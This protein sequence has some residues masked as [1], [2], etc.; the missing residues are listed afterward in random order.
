M[1]YVDSRANVFN[2]EDVYLNSQLACAAMSTTV[3]SLLA[4]CLVAFVSLTTSATSTPCMSGHCH[5][6]DNQL[7]QLKA[8]FQ[9]Q[10]KQLAKHEDGM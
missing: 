9:E 4:V 7:S 10:Q 6:L 1:T 3:W 8:Q 5:I 2:C